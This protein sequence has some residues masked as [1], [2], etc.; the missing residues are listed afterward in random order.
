M[1]GHLQCFIDHFGKFGRSVPKGVDVDSDYHRRRD[2]A[3]DAPGLARFYIG[4]VDPE[5]RPPTLDRRP[6]H[7]VRA[8][9]MLGE[10]AREGGAERARIWIRSSGSWA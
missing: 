7:A 3:P 10:Q 4:R 6:T 2:D 8:F 5:I 9:G 1:P